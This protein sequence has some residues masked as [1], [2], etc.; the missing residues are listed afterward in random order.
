MAPGLVK[1]PRVHASGVSGTFPKKGLVEGAVA[2][3]AGGVC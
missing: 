3:F 1:M 2:V